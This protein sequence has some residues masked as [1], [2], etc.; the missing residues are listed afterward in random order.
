MTEE[1]G[2]VVCVGL[3]GRMQV[4]DWSA[5]GREPQPLTWLPEAPFLDILGCCQRQ[6]VPFLCGL[7]I[8]AQSRLGPADCRRVLAHWD[9]GEYALKD[10]AAEEAARAMRAIIQ[11]CADSTE[12]VELLIEG[13]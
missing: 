3:I 7:D 10:T 2:D 1:A 12:D 11:T 13:P 5:E 8:Y 9:G 4:V 6:K